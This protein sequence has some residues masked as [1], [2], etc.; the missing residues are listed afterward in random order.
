VG[1]LD[2]AK[3]RLKG[4]EKHVKKVRFDIIENSK[5]DKKDKSASSQKS[6]DNPQSR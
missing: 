1:Q 6:S 4:P 2:K 3:T 5:N